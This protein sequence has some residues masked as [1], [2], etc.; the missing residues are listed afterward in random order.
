M[1]GPS[2]YPVK[3]HLIGEGSTAQVF[4][5]RD[6]NGDPAAL[7]L[8]RGTDA[9][10]LFGRER[11]LLRG[12]RHP[13][14]IRVLD[15]GL[16][17]QGHSWILL[18][19]LSSSTLE[20]WRPGDVRIL[21]ALTLVA[22]ALDSLHVHGYGHADL[23][24]ANILLRSSDEDHLVLGDLGLASPLGRPAPGGTPAYLSP[25][26]LDGGPL[27]RRDDLHA[28]AVLVYE[29]IAGRLPWGKTQGDA[30]LGAI[31]KVD[32][33]PL[34][35][36]RPDLPGELDALF[37][38]VFAGRCDGDSLMAWLDPLRNAFGLPRAQRSLFISQLSLE[39]PSRCVTHENLVET[40]TSLLV[41]S[42]A[43]VIP[44]S[45][46]VLDTIG[47]LIGHSL[48]EVRHLL[49]FLLERRLLL[50]VDGLAC[51]SGDERAVADAWRGENRERLAKLS[52]AEKQLLLVCGLVGP[53][54]K[55]EG[56]SSWK[57]QADPKQSIEDLI[58]EGWLERS[59]D[60]HLLATA[61]LPL[62]ERSLP[63]LEPDRLQELLEL[64]PGSSDHFLRIVELA[65]WSGG[66]DWIRSLSHRSLLVGARAVSALRADRLRKVAS[67]KAGNVSY[68][69]LLGLIGVF[70]S[71]RDGDLKTALEGFWTIEGVLDL[72]ASD[73]LSRQL[74][75][76]MV[77]SGRVTEAQDF[78][79]RW[80]SAR[81]AEYRG[82]VLEIK[83]AARELTILSRYGLFEEAQLLGE[84]YEQEFKSR[85]G[86]WILHMGLGNLASEQRRQAESIRQ[87]RLALAG[88]N[89]ED[90]DARTCLDLLLFLAD[91]I[92]TL[93]DPQEL[94]D[95][96]ALL[97]Q[98]AILFEQLGSPELEQWALRIRSTYHSHRG[99]IAA[100]EAT[101]LKCLELA[102]QTGQ[103]D[104]AESM[105]AQIE[106]IYMEKG[107]YRALRKQDLLLVEQL[108]RT[109]TADLQVNLRRTLA[110]SA[111]VCGD[112]ARCADLLEQ[113]TPAAIEL[114]LKQTLA[115]I[116]I[117]QAALNRQL[118]DE[119]SARRLLIAAQEAFEQ[120]QAIRRIHWAVLFRVDLDPEIDEGGQRLAAI[121][122]YA[123]EVQDPS[124]LPQAWRLECRRLRRVGEFESAALALEQSFN[125]TADLV[126]PEYLWPIHLEAAELALA[127]E[128]PAVARAE[129]QRAL[130]INRDLSL[131]FPAGLERERFLARPDR[132]AVLVKLRDLQG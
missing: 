113:C 54:M 47:E 102:R 8:S 51:F 20:V 44:I 6:R 28:F 91:R 30:M 83:V 3:L 103:L 106:R 57:L 76:L 37:Q 72:D 67:R 115:N 129:L 40:L 101:S 15:S 56:L 22:D 53:A 84:K 9:A 33:R 109:D 74:L 43:Q 50:D 89:R 79:A 86:S 35:T 110:V 46:R 5:S 7:K 17:E 116:H 49:H 4:E 31:R 11:D 127:A 95:L 16:D 132:A 73:E 19:L 61:E 39:I 13:A 111:Y 63:P 24:P 128:E 77:D 34:S 130:E 27:D 108:E 52:E 114:D 124:Y 105:Q 87:A 36:S 59:G 18:P 68:P 42:N 93:G 104:R 10:E 96:D 117:L 80:R 118:G 55:D 107:D 75:Y 32:T 122:D 21:E 120:S 82:T 48:R 94:R 64:S 98:A 121:I 90:G 131:H 23:K 38:S 66:G 25:N 119:E 71:I 123:H 26:R 125:A 45:D 70:Q 58:A 100:A 99:D 85:P 12:I 1:T 112:L 88:L 69:L 92:D 2:E 81:E 29:C 14:L 126:S 60:G 62:P 41:T 65:L 78:L 97:A